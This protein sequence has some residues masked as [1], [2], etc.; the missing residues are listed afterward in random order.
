MQHAPLPTRSSRTSVVLGTAIAAALLIV[1]TACT[2]APAP[3]PVPTSSATAS[4]D[5]GA[6]DLPD[7][8]PVLRP[9]G[10]AVQNQLF[11]EYVLEQY[12]VGNG[13]G[14][15]D[16]LVATLAA[17]GFDITTMEVTPEYT[18]IGLAADSVVVSVQLGGECLIGQVFADHRVSLIVPPLATG[19]CLVGETHPI[20]R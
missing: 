11:F 5:P 12:R 10:T 8:V 7:A 4:L 1:V 6:Q 20:Q 19:R 9:G 3:M 15:A 18:A 13:I 2:G 14:T 16:A 17:A